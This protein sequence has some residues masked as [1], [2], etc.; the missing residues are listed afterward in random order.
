MSEK[1]GVFICDC[2][3]NIAD[4]IDT[5]QLAAVA[6]TMDGVASVTIHRLWCSEDG[7][8]EMQRILKEQGIL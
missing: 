4:T 1:I 3:G 2:G 5:K 6:Q 7:R 8:Q